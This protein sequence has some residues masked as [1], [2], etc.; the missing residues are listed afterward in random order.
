MAKILYF[1]PFNGASGDMVLGALLDLGLP[2]EHLEAELSKLGLEPYRLEVEPVERQG[3]RGVNVRVRPVDPAES[4][5]DA[6]HHPVSDETDQGSKDR[7]RHHHGG[8]HPSRGPREIRRLIE[9]SSLDAWVKEKALGIFRRLGE[10][11]AKVH[12]VP[13]DRIHFHEVGAVDALVDIVGACV[14]FR[15]FEVEEFYSAP[16]RLGWGTVTFS[17][18]TWPVPAPATV[19]LL[20]DFP[21]VMGELQ[22]EMTTPTGAAIITTLVEG[23]PCPPVCR[24]FGSGLGTGDR[25]YENAP[26]MLRL[27]L[28]QTPEGLPRH[29]ELPSSDQK[30]VVLEASIDDMDPELFGHFLGIAL[31]KGA[32]DVYYTPLYMKKNRPGLLLSILCLPQDSEEMAELIFRE[33][34]TFGVR[35]S[36]WDRWVLEREIRSLQT[37]LGSV[38]VKIGRWRGD[39]VSVYPEYDDLKTISER[40]NIPLKVV[41]QKV[42]EQLRDL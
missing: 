25:C 35:Y 2:L 10:A 14:G 23:D 32:L 42:L 11:E 3:L 20:K 37:D 8:S 40:E 39:V 4:S 28:G 38:R 18:G 19:E 30:V 36:W 27:M 33:T 7:A 31:K 34:T 12:G 41:R 24:Y 9:S 6:S 26:N 29:G 21:S 15:Y 22:G 17:H 5:S 16:L 1:D 13:L